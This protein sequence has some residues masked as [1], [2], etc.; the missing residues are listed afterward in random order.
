MSGYTN[1]QGVIPAEIFLKAL[2]VLLTAE[3]AVW[4]Q[5]NPEALSILSK[6]NPSQN[7]LEE[8]RIMFVERF[9]LCIPE[10]EPQEP[11]VDLHEVKQFAGESL[12]MYY[13]RVLGILKKNCGKDRQVEKDGTIIKMSGIE[14]CTLN[15]SLKA[16]VRGL[17]DNEVR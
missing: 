10:P 17:C 12:S 13:K 4:A 3:A 8:F 16:W 2:E 7:D 9:P 11:D 14:A 15:T 5:I 1:P 6:I